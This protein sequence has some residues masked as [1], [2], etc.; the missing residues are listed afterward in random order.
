MQL[1]GGCAAA[2]A[3]DVDH[4][5]VVRGGRRRRRSWR[6]F[7]HLFGVCAAQ[8]FLAWCG[9]GPRGPNHRPP[10][11]PQRRVS[12]VGAASSRVT[13]RRPDRN[14][15]VDRRRGMPG[16]Q[17]TKQRSERRPELSHRLTGRGPAHSDTRPGSGWQPLVSA[18]P[19]YLVLG[20]RARR[21]IVPIAQGRIGTENFAEPSAGTST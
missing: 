10:L 2:A 6:N 18:V 15:A 21:G 3:A 8:V 4:G 9:R 17:W 7:N 19:G 16:R 1:L 20:T 13:G 11:V 5:H 12:H 14:L